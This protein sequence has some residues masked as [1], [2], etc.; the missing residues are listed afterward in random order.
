MPFVELEDYRLYY[1]ETGHGDPLV[2]LHGF[3]IDNRMWDPQV[4]FFARKYRV[5]CPDAKGHGQSDAP[6]TGYSR[7]GRVE[8]LRRLADTLQLDRFHLVGL[9]MGGTTAIGFALKYQER[10]SSLTLVSAGAAGYKFSSKISKIDQL[11]RE[12]GIEFAHRKWM[13]W[14]LRPF[15]NRKAEVGKQLEMMMAEHSGAVW[16]DEMRGKY[17]RTSDLDN[18]HRITI[19]TWISA[20]EL[21]KMFVPLAE[22]LHERIKSS[23]LRVFDG[24]G[25]MIN[26]EISDLFNSE[27]DSFLKSVSEP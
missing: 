6:P 5:I 26:M 14:S 9:S 24:V 1:E 27:L 17:L 2:F 7:D 10:L 12:K 20:G 11:A 4:E 25:H 22:K 18:V 23:S 15:K 13:E 16:M 19:P 3:T 8:D 21:D